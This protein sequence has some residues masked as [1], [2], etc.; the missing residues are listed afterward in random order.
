MIKILLTG[1]GTG[2]HFYPLI[3]VAQEINKLVDE[4][5]IANVRMYYFSDAPY[6][7]Q[8]L[9]ENQITFKKINAGKLRMYFSLK[10]FLDI[11]KTAWGVVEAFIAE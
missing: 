5:K 11:F 3:A 4:Q 8:S 10:N 2:G 9:M 6:D 1:G 7:E